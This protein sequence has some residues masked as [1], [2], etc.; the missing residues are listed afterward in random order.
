[1]TT[2]A[3]NDFR[4]VSAFRAVP[5]ASWYD[6][7]WQL[8]HRLTS[9]AEIREYGLD[10]ETD[11]AVWAHCVERFPFAVTPF[12]FSL[13][14]H[15]HPHGPIRRQAFPDRREL[16][17]K[18]C[19]ASDP[20]SEKE[21]SP[22]SGIIHRYPDRALLLITMQ[23]ASYCRHCFRRNQIKGSFYYFDEEMVNGAIRYIAEHCEIRDVLITGG[24][25]LILPDALLEQ[26][27]KK[28][29]QIE[30]VDIIRIGT[31]VPVVLPMRI[32]DACAE[33]LK[34][35]QPLYVITH[36][37]HPNELVEDTVSACSRL[38]D[39]GI[40]LGNQ[41][42]LLKGVNSEAVIMKELMRKLLAARIRPYYLHQCDMTEGL[43]H[44]RTDLSEGVE[45]MKQLHGHLSGLAVPQYAVD[46]PG[47]KGKVRIPVDE[48]TE[49][50][51]KTVASINYNGEPCRYDMS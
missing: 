50:S 28:L 51:D 3:K 11:E 4:K 16:H 2:F 32:T 23:C 38:A 18:A 29:R 49:L 31:R 48:V 39:A 14:D 10:A 9:V 6:W 41:T 21:H 15:E 5:E 27:L 42:V 7:K 36:F 34:R 40:P 46:M 35:Y 8:Q 33:L 30:H 43:S 22:V 44:F 20:L 13:M 12:Y 45:I 19:E 26:V 17:A 25:P 47:G 24:D 37:N 1:M